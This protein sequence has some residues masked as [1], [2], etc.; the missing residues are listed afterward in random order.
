MF[1]KKSKCPRCDGKISGSF[2]YCPFCRLDLRNPE[3]DMKDFGML[4][5]NEVVGYPL[6]GGRGGFGISDK[7]INSIFSTLMKSFEKQMRDVDTE[8]ENLP[9]G[10]KIRFGV[11]SPNKGK[12]KVEKS[13]EITKEQINR[14]AGLPRI[15]AKVNVK[16]L[17]NKIIYELNAPGVEDVNDVFVYKLENG[18]E[19]KAIGKKKVYVNSIPVGLPLKSYKISDKSLIIEFSLDN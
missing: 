3:E 14:M 1:N 7:L 4:G 19:V 12:R 17:N 9:N 18:Y 6:V 15:K 5:K 16:R 11:S 13:Q 10:I 2:D 8:V